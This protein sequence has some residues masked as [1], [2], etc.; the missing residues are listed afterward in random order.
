MIKQNSCYL[1]QGKCN[2]MINVYEI[3]RVTLSIFRICDKVILGFFSLANTCVQTNSGTTKII[4]CFFC[5]YF[6]DNIVAHFTASFIAVR[7][8]R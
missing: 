4:Y 2:K 6:K 8:T 5:R 3:L 7:E 1:H